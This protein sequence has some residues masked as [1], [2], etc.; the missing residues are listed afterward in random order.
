MNIISLSLTKILCHAC[1]RKSHRKIKSQQ[2]S[3]VTLVYSA[4]EVSE[5]M[6]STLIG[7]CG[8]IP[9]SP[10]ILR[11]MCRLADAHSGADHKQLF[12][13]AVSWLSAW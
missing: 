2:K 11:E 13:A 9:C 4:P 3:N 12:P 1:C 7:V 10:L 6:L 5:R 8:D